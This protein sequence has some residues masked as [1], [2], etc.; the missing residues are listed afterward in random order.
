MTFE[1]IAKSKNRGT[2]GTEYGEVILS[3]RN[4]HFSN[5]DMLGNK[6]CKI[7]VDRE[8]GLLAFVPNS[9][10]GFLISKSGKSSC[11]IQNGKIVSEIIRNCYGRYKFY[12][13]DEMLVIRLRNKEV[14]QWIY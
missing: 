4:I 8:E 10:E 9:E 2:R 12:K 3:R 7:M 14:K 1:L 5:K 13:Q 6:F 11:L